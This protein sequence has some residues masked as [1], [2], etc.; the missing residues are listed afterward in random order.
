MSVHTS[1]TQLSRAATSTMRAGRQFTRYS[2]DCHSLPSSLSDSSLKLT[3]LTRSGMTWSLMDHE[4]TLICSTL[5]SS[6]RLKVELP[7]TCNGKSNHSLYASMTFLSFISLSCNSKC[8]LEMRV[9]STPGLFSYTLSVVM[10]E[11]VFSGVSVNHFSSNLVLFKPC[12][13]TPLSST[14][15]KSS[16]KLDKSIS[17]GCWLSPNRWRTSL[18]TRGSV[19]TAR[20]ILNGIAKRARLTKAKDSAPTFP[21]SSWFDGSGPCPKPTQNFQK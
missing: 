6:F 14:T 21:T 9:G 5:P 13:A 11:P 8:Q 4:P 3:R 1:G 12:T 7:A 20:P 17:S 10:P 2:A 16:A 15:L 19:P 18:S